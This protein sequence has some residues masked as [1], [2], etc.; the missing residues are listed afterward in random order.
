[1]RVEC[2]R[3]F[4]KA[5]W[6]KASHDFVGRTLLESGAQF[7]SGIFALAMMAKFF[8]NYLPFALDTICKNL[9]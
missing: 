8:L 2:G 6:N 7:N 3:D 9:I 1:M 4:R 5:R